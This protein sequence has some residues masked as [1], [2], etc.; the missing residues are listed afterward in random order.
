VSAIEYDRHISAII[1]A[2]SSGMLSGIDR[3]LISLNTLLLLINLC[4]IG[5]ADASGE[6]YQSPL[7]PQLRSGLTDEPLCATKVAFPGTYPTR[8]GASS[9]SSNAFGLSDDEFSRQTI[10]LGRRAQ[11]RLM[12]SHVAVAFREAIDRP[13]VASAIDQCNSNYGLLDEVVRN[14]ALCKSEDRCRPLVL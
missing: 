6:V 12:R 9:L 13:K 14:L 10:A 5:I 1:S 2:S 8:L 3:T 7:R 4:L 11:R